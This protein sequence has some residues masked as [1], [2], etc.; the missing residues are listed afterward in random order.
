MKLLLCE[1][2]K[3]QFVLALTASP[4]LCVAWMA[5]QVAA[6]SL[7]GIGFDL[8]LNYGYVALINPD[9]S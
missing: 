3:M 2:L 4:V 1:V 5:G 7:P 8:T 9:I 6:S